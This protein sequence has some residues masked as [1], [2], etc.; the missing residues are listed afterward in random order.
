MRAD[1]SLRRLYDAAGVLLLA[2]FTACA[3]T[4]SGA[5]PLQVTLHDDG[6]VL[7]GARVPSGRTALEIS[8]VGE[9]V[10]EV[11]VFSGATEGRVLPV[12]S[13][14]ADTTGLTLI[15]EVEDILVESNASLVVDL[16]PG[17]YLVMCNLPEHYQTGMW[18]FLTVEDAP[19]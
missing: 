3:P 12:R 9:L 8:N 6:I 17:T 7:G 15:D 14:V 11:E 19:S 18:A 10:H 16:A 1:S 2:L 5:T 4:T 13:S